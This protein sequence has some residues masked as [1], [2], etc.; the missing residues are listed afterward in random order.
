MTD[1]IDDPLFARATL[2][3]EAEKFLGS[4][5]GRFIIERAE[6]EIE[7]A[8]QK[9]AVVDP[10]DTGVIRDLQGQIAVAR[11]IPNWV[12]LAIQDGIQA[13]AIIREE[14]AYED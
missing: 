5:I 6:E 2:G 1:Q 9:L 13:E 4:R 14:E 3:I 7:Q 10:E 8:Y 12:G 11:A